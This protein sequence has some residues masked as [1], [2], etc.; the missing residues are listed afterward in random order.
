MH[1]H[2]TLHHVHHA[3]MTAMQP[4]VQVVISHVVKVVIFKVS[5]HVVAHKNGHVVN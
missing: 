5:V 1:N 2:V 4:Q 3:V